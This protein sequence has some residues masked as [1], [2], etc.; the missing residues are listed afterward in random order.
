MPRRRK[1]KEA[2]ESPRLPQT[3]DTGPALRVTPNTR[4]LY[5]WENEAIIAARDAQVRG[6]FKR[7]VELVRSFL[8]ERSIF[9]AAVNRLAP[10]R[11]LP[12]T[13]TC[14][15]QLTGNAATALEEAIAVFCGRS[16]VSLS[17]AA[18]ADAFFRKAFHGIHVEQM[19][20]ELRADGL[21]EDVFVAPFPLECVEWS[22]IDRCLIAITTA[23]RIPIIHGDG[24]WSVTQEHAESPWHFG[25]VVPFAN[26]WGSVAFARYDESQNAESHGDSKW[27]GTMPE[28]VPTT[29]EEGQALLAQME[30][31]YDRR[32]AVVIPYGSTIKRDEAMSQ[33]YQIFRGIIETG[34]KES[35]R[36]LLGQDGTMTDTG[37]NYIKSKTLFGV[38]N[39]IVEGD[40]SSRGSCISTGTLRPWSLIN[41][42]RWDRL[43][44]SWVMPDPDEDARIESIAGR[45]LKFNEVIAAMR[46]NSF[47]ID[48]KT[49]D[50]VAAE[51]KIPAPQLPEVA[52]PVAVA[53]SNAAPAVTPNRKPLIPAAA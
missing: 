4:G 6:Q 49:V 16:S 50:R 47:L 15:K 34:T 43:E 33:N 25:A 41:H 37:G 18:N 20:W 19:H 9:A 12:R 5:S 26:L 36:I 48:Q 21:R 17:S 44:F 14:A 38:R 24:R 42:G 29:S 39:D 10:H 45:M 27:I 2:P 1:P 30:R 28:G 3:F 35:Q 11:G 53:P 51:F 46:A 40:L 23:G 13:I 7:P 8:T 52:P 32:R 22:E 31:L